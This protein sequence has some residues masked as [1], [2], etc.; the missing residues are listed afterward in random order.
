[1][2]LPDTISVIPDVTNLQDEFQQ[3]KDTLLRIETI[4]QDTPRRG[5]VYTR[6]EIDHMVEERNSKLQSV[7]QQLRDVRSNNEELVNRLGVSIEQRIDTFD[8]K[9]N[10]AMRGFA[11]TQAAQQR[12]IDALITSQRETQQ[13]IQQT[14]QNASIALKA[15]DA[16][17]PIN[18]TTQQ[19]LRSIDTRMGNIEIRQGG[20]EAEQRDSA[21]E[22]N[23]I[24]TRFELMTTGMAGLKAQFATV[25][26]DVIN[27]FNQ[28]KN[29]TAFIQAEQ[30]RRET[31]RKR[32]EYIKKTF[33]SKPVIAILYPIATPL[34]GWI[35]VQIGD[36]LKLQEFVQTV[37]TFLEHL[38]SSL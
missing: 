23:E 31:S 10:D 22:R 35:G 18:E 6:D 8:Q 28:I 11:D 30:A 21:Q 9:F 36:Q 37:I 13:Q 7:E 25:S 16:W 15:V 12:H 33:T 20:I 2:T 32:W 17:T 1:M 29:I 38:T 26:N 27:A 24:N 4:L 34:L 14:S 19:Q 5:E 3:M